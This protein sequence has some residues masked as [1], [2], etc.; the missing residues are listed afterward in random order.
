MKNIFRIYLLMLI[1]SMP[2]YLTG[3]YFIGYQWGQTK[4]EEDFFKKI[5]L[6]EENDEKVRDF[7]KN[8]FKDNTLEKLEFKDD[9]FKTINNTVIINKLI[10]YKYPLTI[11]ELI[12]ASNNKKIKEKLK[13]SNSVFHFLSEYT[14]NY[15]KELK[16]D[17]LIKAILEAK[18]I[19][20]FD[21]DKIVE[22]LIDEAFI[23]T[24]KLLLQTKT[25]IFNS[26]I[27]LSKDTI[28]DL[29]NN[30]QKGYSASQGIIQLLTQ[31]N[32][33]DEDTK[34]IAHEYLQKQVNYN[35]EQLTNAL[36]ILSQ[37]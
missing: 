17:E 26:L 3:Y 5:Y 31:S 4:D 32:S 33:V 21:P 24:V 37:S 13:I 16:K 8:F 10:R 20:P 34:K 15:P 11:Y 25:N 28:Q 22:E 29:F 35:F 27:T 14:F 18:N 23:E 2:Q 7:V 6:L 1:F 30:E 9:H 19:Q 36:N 12:Q